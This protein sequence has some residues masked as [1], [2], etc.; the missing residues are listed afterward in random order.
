MVS[1]KNM[2]ELE[3]SLVG[4]DVQDV[5][6]LRIDDG[7]PVDF[8]S[9]QGIDGIKEAAEGKPKNETRHRGKQVRVR[10]TPPLSSPGLWGDADQTLTGIT[11]VDVWTE[12]EKSSNGFS[13][14]AEITGS[15]C[16][17]HLL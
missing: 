2:E 5:P 7:Q 6:R 16:A 4:E 15:I 13:K 3:N 12:H 9:E 1:H 11:Q 14:N 10:A 8:V 17:A